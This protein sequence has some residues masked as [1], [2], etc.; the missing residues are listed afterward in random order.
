MKVVALVGGVGGARFLQGLNA[1]GADV[2]AVVNTG[3][4]VWM[5]GL[6]ITPDLDTCMYTLGGGIDT[7]RGWG[8]ADESWTVKEELAAYGAEP[9]WFGLGDRDIATH[10]VRTRMLRAGY[11]L[12]AVAEALCDRWKPGV[13]L[14]PMSDDRV[15]THVVVEL[16]GETKAI[17]FQEWW[18]KHRAALPAKSFAFVGAET[19][20]AG[21]GV[22]EAI[23]EADA[24][25]LAPSNPVV[26]IGTILSVPGVR[27]A[28]RK[29]EAGVVGLSPIIGGKPL[30]GMADACLDAIGVETSAEA[31]GRHYGS[32]KCSDGIL[33]AWLVHTGDRADVP[34]VA[35][36]AVPLL[37]SDVDATAQMARAALDLAGVE[38]D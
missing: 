31:V 22:L 6:R 16:E 4:D 2:T 17:H 10:L 15:E 7:E 25:I 36:R 34:G 37:M 21:P 12:S 29:T 26:S 30:R 9:T 28:L 33:D 20:T 1:L 32:R 13:K 23:A 14:L 3:D 19:A 11:P 38:V 35:V 24:V 27:D 5:H 8:R 18:V